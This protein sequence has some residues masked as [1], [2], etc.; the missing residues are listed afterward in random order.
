[1]EITATKVVGKKRFMPEGPEKEVTAPLEFT[2]K[3]P[4]NVE[5]VKGSN[6]KDFELVSK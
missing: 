1:V 4:L 6:T 3:T 2:A 5:I